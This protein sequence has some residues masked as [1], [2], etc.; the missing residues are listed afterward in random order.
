MKSLTI[1]LGFTVILLLPVGCSDAPDYGVEVQEAPPATDR[2][3]NL[4]EGYARTGELDSS[5]MI[6]KDEIKA[7]K[8]EGVA[9]AD[10]LL[11]DAEKLLNA[12]SPSAVRQTAEEMLAKL[13]EKAAAEGSNSAGT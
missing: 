6:L 11:Q 13:P 2:V 4:L 9:N 5:S 3:R 1:L 12:Q 10:A 8:K 7:M